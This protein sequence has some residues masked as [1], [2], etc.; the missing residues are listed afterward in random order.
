MGE[1]IVKTAKAAAQLTAD[2]QALTE[3]QIANATKRAQLE[4]DIAK[5]RREAEEQYGEAQLKRGRASQELLKQAVAN[6]ELAIAK[7]KDLFK[8]E[9]EELAERE[10][11]QRQR[12]E[13]SNET[14]T[15]EERLELAKL[16]AELIKLTA[17]E[18]DAIRGLTRKLN[19]LSKI[20]RQRISAVDQLGEKLSF[21][22]KKLKGQIL[23][24]EGYIKTAEE[25][26][27]RTS[28]LNLVLSQ[29]VKVGLPSSPSLIKRNKTTEKT[30]T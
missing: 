8:I 22:E 7:T 12:V 3:K 19:T 25:Y 13:Q 2:E 16:Q 14:T 29:W 15:R 5:A 1:Q 28:L 4:V 27:N 24:Q 17:E 21:L 11:I 23:A 30:G 18:E 6:Q 20:E 26:K 10:R 9:R